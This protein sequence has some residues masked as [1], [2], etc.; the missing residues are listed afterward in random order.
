MKEDKSQT[1]PL[2]LSLN[3]ICYILAFIFVSVRNTNVKQIHKKSNYTSVINRC[4]LRELMR[5]VCKQ[6]YI[7]PKYNLV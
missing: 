7:Y 3:F 5:Y 2:F 1:S 6:P 4:N